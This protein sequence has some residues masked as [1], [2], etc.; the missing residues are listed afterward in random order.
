MKPFKFVFVKQIKNGIMENYIVEAEIELFKQRLFESWM[1]RSRI[2]AKRNLELCPN[3][4][5]SGQVVSD[6][7]E[8]IAPC[9]SCD[10]FGKLKKK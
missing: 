9:I 7:Q 6:L 1:T 10:G 3:C 4:L 5:G 2:L 8:L